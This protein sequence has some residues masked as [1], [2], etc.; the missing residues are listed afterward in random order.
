MHREDETFTR[1]FEMITLKKPKQCVGITQ[2]TLAERKAE[3]L[4][5]CAQLI[6]VP[7]TQRAQRLS[8]SL[9]TK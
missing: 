4:A 6:S 5:L 2:G 8:L 9:K 3:L 1:T 7:V